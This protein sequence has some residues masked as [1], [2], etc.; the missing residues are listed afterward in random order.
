LGDPIRAVQVNEN[1]LIT[2]SETQKSI[3]LTSKLMKLLE[4]IKFQN[5][6]YHYPASNDFVFKLNEFNLNPDKWSKYETSLTSIPLKT[7]G[8]IK[9]NELISGKNNLL[10]PG[11]RGIDTLNKGCKVEMADTFITVWTTEMLSGIKIKT[12]EVNVSSNYILK[13]TAKSEKPVVVQA[14]LRTAGAP[15]STVSETNAFKVSTS[16]KENL[17]RFSN[18]LSTS[19]PV[20]MLKLE[21]NTGKLTISE[22]SW[23]E[24]KNPQFDIPIALQFNESNLLEEI[25]FEDYVF[26]MKN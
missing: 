14:Y 25:R 17:I 22:L 26:T 8:E 2:L 16:T 12:G 4:E 6:E 20:I 9:S 15:W 19:D 24:V 11:N 18:V 5:N 13:I 21:D 10:S 7:K 23:I 3:K 1:R